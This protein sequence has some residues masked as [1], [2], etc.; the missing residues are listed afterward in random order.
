VRAQ[1]GI[2]DELNVGSVGLKL[3]LIARGERDLYV[4]AAGHSKLWDTCAP[5]V[6]LAE[7]G[8][9]LTDTRGALLDYRG[10]EVG[11][12]RGLIASNGLLHDEV[13]ARLANLFGSP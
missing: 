6:L 3:G 2:S 9:R 8:G 5:E 11:N 1:L 13:V 10:R 7:A 4:N 12:L